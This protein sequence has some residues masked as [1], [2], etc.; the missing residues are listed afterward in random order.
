VRT[1]TIAIRSLDPAQQYS[2]LYSLSPLH[3]LGPDARIRIELRQGDRLLAS[4][5]LHTGDP[6]YYT[7][8]RVAQRSIATPRSVEVS[9]PIPTCIRPMKPS[10]R[11]QGSGGAFRR[12]LRGIIRKGKT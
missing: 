11:M 4:K 10:G 8:F 1:E 7:Q 12:Q 2:F 6:D 3:A 9:K 5:T